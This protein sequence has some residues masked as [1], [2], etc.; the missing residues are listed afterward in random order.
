[1]TFVYDPFAADVMEDPLPF[2]KVLRDQYPAYWLPQ[3]EAW[4]ISRFQDVWDVLSEKDGRITT[5]EGTL[6]FQQ[7]MVISNEGVVP[8]PGYDP[9]QVLSYTESPIHEQVRQ[10]MA[11]ALRRSAARQLEGFVRDQARARLDELVPAGRFNITT[12]YAGMVVAAVMCRLF[13]IPLDHA[14]A[15][16]DAVFVAAP[17][18]QD[19][20]LQA[21]GYAELSDLV[22]DVVRARRAAGADGQYPL[23][24]GL[25]E[26]RLMGRPLTD[27]E[28]SGSV[29]ATVLFGGV[30]TLPK[31]VAH[32]LMEL[33]RHPDQR[34]QVGADPTNCAGAFEEMLRFCAPAQWFS[35]TVRHPITIAGQELGS[36]H[37]IFPLLMSANRDERE[38]DDPDAFH[39]DRPITRHLAFGQGQCF[40]IGNY[41]ARMEGRILLEELLSRTPDYEIDLEESVRP[42]SSFQWGWRVVPLVPGGQPGR[43]R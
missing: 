20:E 25:L 38:F 40:C 34:R 1:V 36:G 30:E 5:T 43:A 41:V 13:G 37:R 10:A 4:A 7:Q 12:E 14:A 35:R 32:G 26:Y 18:A 31:V 17:G 3:Y 9:L 27:E 28:I 21:Q 29:L 39:W 19:P 33:W 2:Y 8:E 16:R 24:D 23:I 15:V 42:P 11:P 22:A 6:M